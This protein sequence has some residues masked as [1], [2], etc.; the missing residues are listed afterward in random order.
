M[1]RVSLS[2]RFVVFLMMGSALLWMAAVHGLGEVDWFACFDAQMQPD[3]YVPDPR[4]ASM[5][6]GERVVALL[7]H[8]RGSPVQQSALVVPFLPLCAVA[9]ASRRPRWVLLSAS[10]V[11]V[12]ALLLTPF[13]PAHL[14]DCDRKGT[15]AF[16]TLL[17]G[18]FVVLPIGLVLL[19]ALSV[20]GLAER[21][22]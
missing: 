12:S 9:L 22:A 14:H 6:I 8:P 10:A 11:V 17:F 13:D 19:V 15:Y 16:G 18:Y 3:S 7:A 20:R 5:T 2:I 4:V 21:A 1:S